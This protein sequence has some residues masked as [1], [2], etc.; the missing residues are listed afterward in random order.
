MGLSL[1]AKDM[2]RILADVA[3]A[4]HERIAPAWLAVAAPG[5][6]RV[7]KSAGMA[8]SERWRRRRPW[9]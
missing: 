2:R 8:R 7:E 1:E 5:I 9:T 3:A 6:L 4:R